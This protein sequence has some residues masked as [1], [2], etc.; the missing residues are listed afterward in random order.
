MSTGKRKRVSLGEKYK[1]ITDLESGLKPSKVAEKYDVPRNTISTWLKKKE[2]IKSAF[3]SG[4]VSSK[5]K[6]MRIGQNDNLEKA[7]FSWFKKMRTNNLP[8]NGTVVKEKAISYAKELQIEGFKASNGW[9]ERW[10]SR[11]NVSFKAIAGEEKSV[12]P[13]LTSSWWETYLHTI[14]SRCDLKDIYNADEFGLFY[15]ALP[16]KTM[17]LKGEKCTGG[18]N[19][20]TLCFLLSLQLLFQE[21]LN[22]I[23]SQ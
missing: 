1:A 9:F 23:Y 14:L 19:R 8:V 15:Q 3:K 2:E 4:E 21:Y 17:E 6:N 12:T 16:T 10:K 7:L 11:F 22:T 5:R 20:F 13:E 18:K